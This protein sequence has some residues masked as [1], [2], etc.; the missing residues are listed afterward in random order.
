MRY[1]ISE[2]AERDLDEIFVYWADR[3]SLE[4]EDRITDRITERV[5]LLGEHP[6][7]GRPADHIARGVKCFPAGRHLIYYRSTRRG[8]ESLDIFHVARDQTRALMAAMK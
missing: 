6:N 2:D 5:W 4:V 1:R 3:A 7:A 8:T